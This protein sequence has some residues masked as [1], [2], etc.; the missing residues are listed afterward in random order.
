MRVLVDSDVLIEFLRGRET[1][2]ENIRQLYSKGAELCDTAV[3]RSE[4]GAGVR[5]SELPRVTSLFRVLTCLP[6]GAREGELAGRLL[7]RF[8]ASHGL[9]LGDALM[10]ATSITHQVPL[11]TLNVRH[12]RATG[13]A[14]FQP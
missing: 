6:L 13:A 14:L 11:W 5:V 2:V 1:V 7:S 10:A 8:R 4:I 12:F 9:E 3:V